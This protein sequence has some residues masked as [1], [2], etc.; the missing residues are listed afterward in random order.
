MHCYCL[1]GAARQAAI[2]LGGVMCECTQVHECETAKALYHRAEVASERCDAIAEGKHYSAY[3]KHRQAA[4]R[5]LI[6]LGG[7]AVY[8]K[9]V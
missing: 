4:L 8:G 3:V 2:G 7:K 6:A 9:E 5:R 1:R